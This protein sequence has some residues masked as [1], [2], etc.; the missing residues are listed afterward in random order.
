MLGIYKITSPTGN[1]YIGQSVDIERRWSFHSYNKRLDTPIVRSFKKHGFEAHK[2]EVV[3]ELP[4]DVDSKTLT[5]YEQLYID[6]YRDAGA[7]L[8]NANPASATM[9]GFKHREDVKKRSSEIRAG[10]KSPMEGKKHTP[11]SI[12]KIKEKRAKQKIV[13]APS[14]RPTKESIAKGVA[15]RKLNA[16]VVIVSDETRE[17]LRAINTGKKH[18]DETKMKVSA[19]NARYW[20][21]KK[22]PIQSEETR[23]KKSEKLKAS[24][25]KRKE[26]K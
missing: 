20:L 16:K 8:L 22:G 21:G 4:G 15:T 11:E 25:A 6:L 12:Q 23:K 10:W 26:S 18:S 13:K 24:W 19:N 7:T 17:K 3:H 9:R 5:T 1:V 14:F 2:F